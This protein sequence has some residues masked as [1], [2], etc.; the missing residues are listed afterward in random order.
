MYAEAC[1]EDGKNLFLFLCVIV[2]SFYSHTYSLYTH[3]MVFK[4]QQVERPLFMLV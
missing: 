2:S 1:G 3:Y 4:Q